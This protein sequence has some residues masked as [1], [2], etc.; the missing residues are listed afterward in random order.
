[1]FARSKGHEMRFLKESNK[2]VNNNPMN[3]LARS[4]SARNGFA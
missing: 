2:F 4:L 1:M 3:N